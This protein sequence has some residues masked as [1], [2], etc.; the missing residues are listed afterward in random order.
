[1]LMALAGG[2][3]ILPAAA[4]AAYPGVATGRVTSV[5]Y[6]SA[7]L[8][9]SVNPHGGETVYYFEYGPT[10][11]YGAQT[12]L[13]PVG[14][15]TTSVPASAPISG[16]T[17]ATPYHYRLVA[18]GAS[19][20]KTGP[21]RSF[22]SA[23]IPLTV[24]LSTT[25]NPIVFGSPFYVEGTFAGTGA[26]NREVVLQAQ[27]FPYTAGFANIGNPQVTNATGGFLFPFTGL[28]QNAQLR[29]MTVGAPAVISTVVTETVAVKVSLSVHTTTPKRV[30]YA[31]LSG[32][33]TPPEAGALVKIQRFHPKHGWKDVAG[34][35]VGQARAGASS[36]FAHVMRVYIGLYRVQVI[37]NDGGHAS[38]YSRLID[39]GG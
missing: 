35:S 34:T 23:A 4:Q 28:L 5:T 32:T 9:G 7:T 37:V 38:S 18:T 10:T 11:A 3:L 19:G 20:T 21:D 14:N 24:T 17:P 8:T 22:T 12:T 26:A 2:A 1:M 31:R 16:L 30:G 25:P 15:G 6:E 33:V 27:P 13:T 39:I 29:V 36:T